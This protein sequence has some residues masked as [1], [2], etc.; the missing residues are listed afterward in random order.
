M[1]Y[2]EIIKNRHSI[3]SYNNKE[4]EKEKLDILLKYIEQC[5]QESGLHIQLCMDDPAVFTGLK[6]RYGKLTNVNNYIALVG[7]KSKN[8]EEN[9]GYYG[10]KIVLK[11]TELELGT[12]WV[13]GT[14]SKGKSKISLSS[15]EKLVCVIASGYSDIKGFPHKNKPI[16]ELCNINSTS[17]IWFRNGV[18]YAMLAPTAMNQQKFFFTLQDT[19]VTVKPGRGFYTKLDL[20]IVKYHFEIGAGKENF[21]WG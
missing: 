7:K 3:R 6:A 17:P 4:I 13:A 5:N 12:C 16:E 21:T 14:Y 19:K 9:I 15:D 2:L 1:N 11:A 8:L 10:E 18:E 20:G